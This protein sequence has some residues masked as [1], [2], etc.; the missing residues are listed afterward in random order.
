MVNQD[1]QQLLN[2]IA[3]LESINDQL[4]TE[5]GAVDTLM[6]MVGF[7]D[8]LKTVEATAQELIT[9]GYGEDFEA[10]LFH[11]DDEEEKYG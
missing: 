9:R 6:R 10:E 3:R 1:V 4:L 11:D 7:S 5:L 2:K 8:G